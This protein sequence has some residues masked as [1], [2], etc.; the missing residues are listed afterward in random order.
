MYKKY[1]DEDLKEAYSTMMDYSGKADAGILTEIE[2]RGGLEKFLR[3]IE[4]QRINQ[5]EIGRIAKEI[6]LLNSNGL[7][8]DAIKNSV[9]SDILSKDE[10][11]Y[12]IERKLVEYQAIIADRTI[13]SKTIF[14][15][16][17][18]I[19]LGSVLGCIFLILAISFFGRLVFFPLVGVYIICYFTIKF[20]T[21]Q[22]RNNAVVF[23]ASFLSTVISMLLAIGITSILSK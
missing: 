22:S 10:L 20:F 7:N 6:R 15:S 21:K 16:I 9:Q 1:S 11:E 13:T 2:S 4:I 8:K 18:G 12:L 17:F 5:T 14:G 23:I 19:I 3:Q